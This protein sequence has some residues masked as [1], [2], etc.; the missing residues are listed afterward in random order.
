MLIWVN[1]A[2]GAGKT[3]TVFELQRR[4]ADAHVADPELIG[5]ALLK[6][7]PPEARADFQDLPQWRSAVIDTLQQ[8]TLEHVG[9][10]LVPMTIVRDDYFEEIIGGLRSRQVDVRHY[11]LT[12]S[13]D[14]LRRRLSS[15]IAFIGS[16]FQ[17]ETWAMKQIPRC[18]TALAQH[19]YATHVPTDDRTI[20][21]VV[22]WI[23]HDAGLT[24]TNARLPSW[25][26]QLRRF[27]VGL[28]HVR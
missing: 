25:Q 2:F 18:I 22:E 27:N 6:T 1:G 15:R 19:R 3:Q 4:L 23:A 9:P 12:A 28:R 5:F 17:R 13:A 7:L 8:A 21:D 14:T 20:N 24:L 11:A 10:V 26:Y 16:G